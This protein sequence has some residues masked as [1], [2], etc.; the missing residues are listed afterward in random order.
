LALP[1][2]ATT[3][4]IA[5]GTPF[6]G[7]AWTD[8]V[9]DAAPRNPDEILIE[10]YHAYREIQQWLHVGRP[11]AGLLMITSHPGVHYDNGILSAVLMRTSP[12]CGDKRLYWENAGEQVYRFTIFPT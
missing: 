7:G 3:A 11:G 8:V 10:D 1:T 5:Y 6:H 2:A 9:Q 4:D 12:S